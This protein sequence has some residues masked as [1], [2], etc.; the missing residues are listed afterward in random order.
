[1][2]GLGRARLG[3]ARLGGAR[4]DKARQGF[5]STGGR[6][7]KHTEEK[8][9]SIG[10]RSVETMLVLDALRKVKDDGRESITYQ[11]LS[12]IVGFDVRAS[13]TYMNTARNVMRHEHG[14]DFQTI[15]GVGLKVAT[16]QEVIGSAQRERKIISR[17][18]KRTI[19]RLYQCV[20]YDDLP[21]ED[22]TRW[23]AEFALQ[24][25]I[26][27]ASKEKTAAAINGR[28]QTTGAKLSLEGTL[29]TLKSMM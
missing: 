26:A 18:A 8:D 9:K 12:K 5:P 20:R 13:R 21:K 16:D 1:M 3:R 27:H 14:V 25:V 22:Q 6:A 28:V 23:N 7:M 24:A 4:Q 19:A 17:R 2:A 15:I 11:Q 29:E 10:V